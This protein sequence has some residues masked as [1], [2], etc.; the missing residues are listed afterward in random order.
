LN[1]T[2]GSK[3]K[4][5]DIS[6]DE[7]DS[8]CSPSFTN[9]LGSSDEEGEKRVGIKETKKQASRT[10]RK[11][12]RH[13][14]SPSSAY[15]KEKNS[16]GF[17]TPS[18]PKAASPQTP[19]GSTRPAAPCTPAS[20]FQEPTKQTA[21]TPSPAFPTTRSYRKA[22][23]DAR[24]KISEISEQGAECLTEEIINEANEKDARASVIE[25]VRSGLCS[26][27]ITRHAEEDVNMR[28][29]VS[30]NE[31]AE[32]PGRRSNGK[33]DRAKHSKEEKE[34][35]WKTW[36]E[37][38]AKGDRYMAKHQA[39]VLDEEDE[40]DWQ[41]DI[42]KYRIVNGIIVH[43]DDAELLGLMGSQD[44]HKHTRLPRISSGSRA[45]PQSLASGGGSVGPEAYVQNTKTD[46]E[47]TCAQ[48]SLGCEVS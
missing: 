38:R 5:V 3:R 48:T 11:K 2:K 43:D 41:P 44:R 25:E 4:V 33:I 26:M 18:K 31:S 23:L 37:S 28:A 32:A 19:T 30:D 15:R 22:K 10:T 7:D 14:L 46:K 12:A 6:S 29:N 17:L 13:V 27:S 40:D 34:D 45:V 21:V 36:T 8:V 35:G 42:S 20:V 9:K 24:Q 16:F 39:S 1:V 47:G